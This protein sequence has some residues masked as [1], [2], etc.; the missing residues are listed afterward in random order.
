MNDNAESIRPL[1]ENAQKRWLTIGVI[2][3]VLCVAGS[4]TNAE[5]FFRSYLFGYMFWFNLTL[6]CL[7]GVMAHNLTGGDWGGRLADSLENRH[8]GAAAHGAAGAADP[9]WSTEDL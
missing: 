6:G 7:A 9:L 5:Q 8:A 1:L 4:L 3:A 2:G